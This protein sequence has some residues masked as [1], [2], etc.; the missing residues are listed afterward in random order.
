MF[1]PRSNPAIHTW[2][3]SND[4]YFQCHLIFQKHAHARRMCEPLSAARAERR[5]EICDIEFP[6]MLPAGVWSGKRFRVY[7]ESSC[8]AHE[9]L[10]RL[11]RTAQSKCLNGCTTLDVI[12]C[13]HHTHAYC[14]YWRHMYARGRKRQLDRITR[15]ER[16]H[17]YYVIVYRPAGDEFHR[18]S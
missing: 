10:G 14:S 15:A 18:P 2:S 11:G 7:S 5:N 16:S 9:R 8:S 17:T 1:A 12:G 4:T 6:C 3:T 13:V